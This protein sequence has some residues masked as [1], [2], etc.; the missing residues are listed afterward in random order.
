MKKHFLKI[1]LLLFLFLITR[2]YNVYCNGTI[3]I[4]PTEMYLST[5]PLGMGNAYV[6]VADDENALFSN[7]AG[8]GYIDKRDSSKSIIKS[9]SF[10][11]I[12]F[13]TNSFTSN[14]IGIYFDSSQQ[15]PSNITG[16]AIANSSSNDIVFSRLSLFPNIVIGRFQLGFLAD[17]ELNGFTT[18]LSSPKLSDFSSSIS[19]ITYDRTFS[20]F[21]REQLGPVAGFSFQISKNILLGLG[22]RLMLR[23]TII[24]NIEENQ[25]GPITPSLQKA[26][27]N[28]NKTFGYA[29][30]TG[31]LIPFQNVLNPKIAVSFLDVGDTTYKAQ[32]STYSNEIEKMNI[33]T[34]V[35]INPNLSK[36]IGAIISIEANR[37]N[38]S[39]INDRDKIS[40]GCEISFGSHKGSKAP[41]S[42]RTGYGMRSLSA[43]MS[44]DLIFAA[45][46]MATYG[47]TV[48]VNNGYVIDRRYAIKLTV[49]LID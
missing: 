10:P 27:N 45:L 46:E 24:D 35:S 12:T 41:F 5:R 26:E 6:A 23:E 19:P 33:K 22:S 43:G 13:S 38:D 1:K 9:A 29:F 40:T 18:I 44:L 2:K 20:I 36:N 34:G 8:I 30:D 3:V 11:N 4:P 47:E 21:Y 17:V 37:I 7:P 14:L 48:T 15:Y 31:I 49:D 42:L 39:R 25:N 28:R 32:N 16:K